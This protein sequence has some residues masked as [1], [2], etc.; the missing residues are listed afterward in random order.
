M[1]QGFFRVSPGPKFGP[2]LNAEKCIFLKI[3]PKYSRYKKL[4]EKFRNNKKVF[5]SAK[6]RQK[7]KP[8]LSQLHTINNKK[9]ICILLGFFPNLFSQFQ[10]NID[11]FPKHNGPGPWNQRVKNSCGSVSKLSSPFVSEKTQMSFEYACWHFN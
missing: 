3:M 4:F 2:I 7:T 11:I 9:L 5:F 10:P 1:V 6:D 8:F